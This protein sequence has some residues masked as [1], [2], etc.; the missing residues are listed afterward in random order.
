MRRAARL[1]RRR[2][3]RASGRRDRT[4]AADVA[5]T[6]R[7]GFPRPNLRRVYPQDVLAGAGVTGFQCS[8][9]QGASSSTQ[10]T[11]SAP[12]NFMVL[13]SVRWRCLNAWFFSRRRRNAANSLLFAPVGSLASFGDAVIAPMK[14][15]TWWL[16]HVIT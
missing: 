13:N 8:N 11:A 7:H 10:S 3:R 16:I 4:A 2:A 1:P 15:L 5:G 14:L 9:G 12:T 6:D